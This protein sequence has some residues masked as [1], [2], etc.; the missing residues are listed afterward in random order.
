MFL[1]AATAAGD[2][3]NTAGFAD[4]CLDPVRANVYHMVTGMILCWH[5]TCTDRFIVAASKGHSKHPDGIVDLPK[6][7]LQIYKPLVP[8]QQNSSD[9]GVF[10]LKYTDVFIHALDTKRFK[11]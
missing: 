3:A 9:C 5:G 2:L 7:K 10:V 11:V 4:P 8:R 6:D 1:S